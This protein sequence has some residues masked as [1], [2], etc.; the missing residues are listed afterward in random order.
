MEAAAHVKSDLGRVDRAATP[1]APPRWHGRVPSRGAPS[2]WLPAFERQNVV[3]GHEQLIFLM[4][5]L[6]SGTESNFLTMHASGERAARTRAR[7][8]LRHGAR[9]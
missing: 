8:A 7:S 6:G 3:T 9:D 5:D 2:A 1:C 4:L